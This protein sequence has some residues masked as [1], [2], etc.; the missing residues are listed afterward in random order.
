M[1]PHYGRALDLNRVGSNETAWI[2]KMWGTC[3][4]RGFRT[5]PGVKW[6]VGKSSSLLPGKFGGK[7]MCNHLSETNDR[8]K[9]NHQAHPP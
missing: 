2:V 4:Y 1:S 8:L 9:M 5:L 3:M 6:H 7:L